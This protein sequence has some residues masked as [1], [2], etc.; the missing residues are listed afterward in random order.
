MWIGIRGSI[1]LAA[2]TACVS[3]MASTARTECGAIPTRKHGRPA[4][5]DEISRASPA[6]DSTS[7]AEAALRVVERAMA[8]AAIGV[9]HRQHR[10]RDSARVRGGH[11]A[12]GELGRVGVRLAV[13]IVCR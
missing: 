4:C 9:E 1:S 13:A 12:L 3:I 10:D 7:P 8:K 5:Q 11:D 2:A 6:M